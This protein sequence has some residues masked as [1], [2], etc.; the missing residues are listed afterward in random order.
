MRFF[1]THLRVQVKRD[2]WKLFHKEVL[3]CVSYCVKHVSMLERVMCGR[4]VF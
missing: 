4:Y 3:T 1:F 2:Y